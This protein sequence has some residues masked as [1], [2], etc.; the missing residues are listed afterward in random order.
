MLLNIQS[1]EDVGQM[2]RILGF[3]RVILILFGPNRFVHQEENQPHQV[4]KNVSK[5]I[6]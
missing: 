3:G 1:F 6:K 4:Q 5:K 2:G